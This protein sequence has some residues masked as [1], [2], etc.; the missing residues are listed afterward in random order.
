M[1]EARFALL[2]LPDAMF[3]NHRSAIIAAANAARLPAIYPEREYAARRPPALA[4]EMIE[5]SR[6][7]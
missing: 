4:D 5:R 2:R 6:V 3:W 1:C 7:L